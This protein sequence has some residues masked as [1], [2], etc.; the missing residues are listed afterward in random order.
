MK[1]YL[2]IILVFTLVLFR[3]RQVFT[4][5]YDPIYW[6]KFYN[7]SQYN[8]GSREL[9]DEGV[10]RYVGYRLVKGDNPFYLHYWIPP[11]GK[12]LYGLSVNYF[13]NPYITSVLLYTLSCLVFLLLAR[14]LLPS[15]LA[16]FSLVLFILNP[17][18]VR[19]VGLTM[20]D[21]PLALL[22]LFSLLFFVKFLKNSQNQKLLLISAVFLGLAAGTKPPFYVLTTFTV[23]FIFLFFLKKLSQLPLF[24]IFL[25]IGYVVSYV[26]YFS[27]HPNPMP[28]LRL[29]QKVVEFQAGMRGTNFPLNTFQAIFVGSTR[30]Y[31]GRNYP[32][33]EWYLLFPLFFLSLFKIFVQKTSLVEKYLILFTLVYLLFSPLLDFWPRYFVPIL[34]PLTIVFVS[35]VKNKYLL[36]LAILYSLILFYA[37]KLS[38]LQ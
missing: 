26:C 3:Y 36:S 35:T 33:S 19:Q 17:L 32:F 37:T 28:W 27:I 22:F 8:L 30:H 6:E 20:L 14:E 9:S 2:A 13:G 38:Q 18:L 25:F 24:I 4:Y 34:A 5:H 12:Y 21:L 11:F 1:K 23:S 15:N 10:L 16:L 7:E 31:D 29:H